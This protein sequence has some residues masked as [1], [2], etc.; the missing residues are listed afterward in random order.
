MDNALNVCAIEGVGDLPCIPK[1]FAGGQRA[2]SK[3]LRKRLSLDVLHHQV[4]RVVLFADVIQRADIRVTEAGECSR[5][6][7]EPLPEIRGCGVLRSQDFD[8]D[9][10]VDARV[11]SA[12]DLTHTPGAE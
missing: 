1:C 9:G 10:T 7:L 8:C 12:V 2:V 11:G 5:L 4:Q 6:P 3:T